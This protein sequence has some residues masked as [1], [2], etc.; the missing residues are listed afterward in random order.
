MFSRKLITKL[1]V[2][3]PKNLCRL[4]LLEGSLRDIVETKLPHMIEDCFEINITSDKTLPQRICSSCFR[5]IIRF[6]VYK[7][8]VI[9]AQDYLRIY[10]N[11]KQFHPIPVKEKNKT[12]SHRNK[13]EELEN[14]H[15]E[16]Q[17]KRVE[18]KKCMEKI[19]SYNFGPPPLVPIPPSDIVVSTKKDVKDGLLE[20]TPDQM[21][22]TLPPLIPLRTD[23]NNDSTLKPLNS[24]IYSETLEA[25]TLQDCNSFSCNICQEKLDS[26]LKLL[27]H[28]RKHKSTR[29]Y[30]C[31]ICGKRYSTPSTFR[32]HMRTH[33][34]ER[35]FECNICHKRFARWT[36]VK[37]HM[38][39]H[40]NVQPFK[41]E[42][43]E[44]R[45]KTSSNLYRHK[46]L[47][48]G[49]GCF[50]C[51]FCEKTFNQSEHLKV[52][53]RIHHTKEKPYL[54]SECGK[55]FVNL[56][57]L[58][59]HEWIHNGQKPHPCLLCPKAYTNSADLKNHQLKIHQGKTVQKL[60]VCSIC[61]KRFTHHCRL[62][63][64]MQSHES[65]DIN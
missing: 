40:K 31:N 16:I 11:A 46:K 28:L 14:I 1:Q 42:T 48:S 27:K 41:C 52:H 56:Q 43:C 64:H 54:C 38:N 2:M 49:T 13:F 55:G 44:K 5:Q 6:Y 3:G 20:N 53:E 22:P 21:E 10:T 4:C 9:K 34:G 33:T 59:R 57:R 18:L 47:H 65:P 60:F 50:K 58:K 29:H 35:P 30:L 37:S 12:H 24:N 15:E 26:R 7:Q 36:G 19:I 51:S 32:V 62:I 39:I 45:F 23:F 63:K 61:N 25:Q 17:K 8:K